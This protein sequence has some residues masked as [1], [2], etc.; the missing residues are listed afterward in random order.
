MK[1]SS[2]YA[3]DNSG[4]AN[5]VRTD[6]FC[7]NTI[8]IKS[9]HVQHKTA[10]K[11]KHAYRTVALFEKATQVATKM[12]VASPLNRRISMALEIHTLAST[13]VEEVDDR[14]QS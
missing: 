13:A 6:D 7:T 4:G 1:F 10:A 2:L 14:H 5:N 8:N 11:T 9:R 12:T 3:V